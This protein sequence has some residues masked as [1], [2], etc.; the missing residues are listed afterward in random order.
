MRDL[1]CFW[2]DDNTY[3]CKHPDKRLANDYDFY[4]DIYDGACIIGRNGEDPSGYETNLGV[5][6]EGMCNRFKER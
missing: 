1:L 2:Y 4:K 6:Q 3:K 5:S